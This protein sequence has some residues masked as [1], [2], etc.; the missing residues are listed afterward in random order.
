MA[1]SFRLACMTAYSVWGRKDVE[2]HLSF[3]PSRSGGHVGRAPQ[4]HSHLVLIDQQQLHLTPCP[5]RF[6][7]QVKLNQHLTSSARQAAHTARR[8]AGHGP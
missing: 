8:Q 3:S 4:R 7:F 5:G 1:S 6:N 2:S